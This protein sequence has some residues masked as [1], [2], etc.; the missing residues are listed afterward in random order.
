MKKIIFL[1]PYPTESNSKEGMMQRVKAIDELFSEKEYAKIYIVIR[2]KSIRSE[3]KEIT[4]AITEFRLSIWTSFFFLLSLFSK[5]SLIYA[6]SLYGV[7]I[8]GFLYL[9]KVCKTNFIWDVHGIIPEELR[10]AGKN[11]LK[12]L[13]YNCLEKKVISNTNKIIVVTNAMAEHLR[14]KYPFIK[15]QFFIYPILPI[16]IN[17]DRKIDFSESDKIN[18]IY[19]GN[20]QEYQNIP[21]MIRSIKKLVIY[22]C[23]NF[24]ILTGKKKEMEELLESEGLKDKGNI[25][26]DSVS[27]DE[28]D[29]YYQQA[30]YGYILRDNIDVNN[31]ACPT[32]IVEY[33]AYGITRI[34]LSTAIGDFKEMD[35]ESIPIT[36]LEPSRLKGKKSE[37]NCEIYQ[38]LLFTYTSDKLRA[39]I[40]N[41]L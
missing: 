28:L 3:K 13:V 32:K 37:K 11:K 4:Q 15:A 2:F 36:K 16:T 18:F 23:I 20:M 17:S 14:T 31:V 39:F 9:W 19:A 24:Y 12:V 22:P 34:V 1:A 30:H 29:Y 8:A 7:S 35:F 33:L 25:I 6:H 21:L 27:P 38:Y 5:A 40:M 10:F 41:H 26:V